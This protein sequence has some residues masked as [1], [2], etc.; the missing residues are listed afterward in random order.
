MDLS[1]SDDAKQLLKKGEELMGDFGINKEDLDAQ[2]LL[3]QA[4][5]YIPQVTEQATKL[6]A[7]Q[8]LDTVKAAADLI[9]QHKGVTD[10]MMQQMMKHGGTEDGNLSAEALLASAANYVE[11]VD[12]KKITDAI[13]NLDV[14]EW[15]EWGE[16]VATDE[17]ERQKLVNQVKDSAL[18][19]LL[20]YLPSIQVPPIQGEKDNVEYTISNIDLG[21]FK[22]KKEGVDVRQVV[23]E[24]TVRVELADFHQVGNVPLMHA[25]RVPVLHQRDRAAVVDPRLVWRPSVRQRRRRAN[26][27][28]L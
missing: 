3:A 2:K 24:E 4:T 16:K 28:R 9:D 18:E 25:L 13:G 22:I 15:Q 14:K 19:F 12:E 21:G 7:D 17:T 20:Q 8:G 26:W 5:E 11:Q 23:Q 1:S 10:V 6:L 27:L